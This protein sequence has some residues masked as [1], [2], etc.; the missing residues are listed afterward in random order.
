ML[1]CLLRA[2]YDDCVTDPMNVSR[3]SSASR[4]KFHWFDG[5]DLGGKDAIEVAVERCFDAVKGENRVWSPYSEIM[6][7]A[8]FRKRLEAA[9]QGRLIPV[10]EVKEAGRDPSVPLYEIRWQN[11]IHVTE[12]DPENSQ[13]SHPSVLV[14]MY[15]SEPVSMPDYFIG[16]HSHEKRIDADNRTISRWQTEEVRIAQQKYRLGEKTD[17]DIVS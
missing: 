14:R 17:W 12:R 5:A 13:L 8:E 15:H 7:R 6:I 2:D 9:C 16:H 10:D 11:G 1:V 4:L 3:C